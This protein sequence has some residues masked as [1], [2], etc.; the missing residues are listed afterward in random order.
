MRRWNRGIQCIKQEFI[1][2]R[3]FLFAICLFISLLLVAYIFN[4]K[5]EVIAFHPLRSDGRHELKVMTWNVHCSKGADSI[6]QRKIAELVLD[7]DA[8]FVL[9]NEYYQDSCSVT[10]SLLRMRYPFT[11]ESRSHR[12]CGDI[13]YSK[14]IMS[15][16]SRL[17]PP[18]C[19]DVIRSIKATIALNEDSVRIFGV[20]LASNHYDGTTLDKELDNDTT[21]YDQYNDAQAKRC[22]QAHWIKEAVLES[23]HPV[24]VMGDMNDFNCSA[25]LDTLISSGLMDAWWEGGN[26]YGCTFHAGWMRLRIDHILHS[27]ELKLESIKVIDTDLSDHN[28]VVAEFGLN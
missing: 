8:D 11:E 13:F 19:R 9:L 20:H 27:K 2:R 21:S 17:K 7:V 10:D 3:C 6:R 16:T 15:N 23:K 26:G 12:R 18:R 28:P 4:K 14:H 22:F 1:L 24:I 5:F 25:P